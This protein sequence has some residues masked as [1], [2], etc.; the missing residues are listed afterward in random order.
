MYLKKTDLMAEYSV[1]RSTVD[2]R[3]HFIKSLIGDRY[4]R[5][6]VCHTR[7]LV[8]IRDDVFK[9][10]MLNGDAIERGIAPD[11]KPSERHVWD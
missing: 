9:D 1:S 3:L 7:R 6:A 4:P 11:F 8:R 2:E 10:A 5:D